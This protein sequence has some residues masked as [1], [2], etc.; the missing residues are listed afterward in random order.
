MLE[1]CQTTNQSV[2]KLLNVILNALL[3]WR[4]FLIVVISGVEILTHFGP[5]Y[6]DSTRYIAQSNFF[7]DRLPSL[8][9]TTSRVG[10]PMLAAAFVRFFSLGTSFAIVNSVFWLLS[11]VLIFFIAKKILR[12]SE[13]AL[14]GAILFSTSFPMLQN[15][16]AVLTDSSGYFFMGL[17]IFFALKNS[18]PKSRIL[19]FL[20]GFVLGVGLFF[21]D[22]VILVIVLLVLLRLWKRQG[23]LETVVG[24]A[25]PFLIGLILVT[26]I[27]GWDGL[28]HFLS[29]FLHQVTVVSRGRK[30]SLSEGI[31]SESLEIFN[32]LR[33]LLI[34]SYSF[35]AVPSILPLNW[36]PSIIF[37]VIGLWSL[38]ERKQLAALSLLVLLP[39]TVVG[40]WIGERHM[41][42]L[43]PVAIPLVIGGLSALLTF[44][45]SH[46]RLRIREKHCV[47]I[48]F[49]ILLVM[50]AY[51]NYR[52]PYSFLPF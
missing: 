35:F 33:W 17:G 19:Y 22:E 21:R 50:A 28:Q 40:P 26:L 14:L 7:L 4:I 16:T 12:N 1:S 27:R 25:S 45:F 52:I 3:D 51:N 34:F 42:Y 10:T 43:Y 20:E 48:M 5:T 18:E 9:P 31:G 15:G 11:A 49:L 41:F 46:L 36:I 6:P 13:L 2:K 23:I 39:A 30:F 38:R 37:L 29:S 44:F 47:Y 8:F 24:L 32:P